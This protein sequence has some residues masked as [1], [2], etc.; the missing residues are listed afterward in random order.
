MK[1]DIE[2][3]ACYF[4]LY[5]NNCFHYSADTYRE[6][7]EDLEDYV[8]A[9]E[10]H[11]EKSCVENEYSISCLIAKMRWSTL[12]GKRTKVAAEEFRRY[13][14]RVRALSKDEAI[15]KLA[16]DK[17]IIRD[18]TVEVVQDQT[19]IGYSQGVI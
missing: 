3:R 1:Y 14:A 4:E 18:L 5:I 13:S 6:A 8:Q 17:Y 2:T 10:K 16:L 12:N 11:T 19:T 7:L 9:T 15:T